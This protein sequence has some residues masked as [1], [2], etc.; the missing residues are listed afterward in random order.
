M[1]PQGEDANAITVQEFRALPVYGSEDDES[2]ICPESA[3][4]HL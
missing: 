2:A 1:T 4:E 3:A